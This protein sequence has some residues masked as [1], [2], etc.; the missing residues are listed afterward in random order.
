MR[1]WAQAARI[2]E[3]VRKQMGRWQPS[4]DEEYERSV[5]ANV[6]RAQSLVAGFVKENKGRS[7]PFDEATVLAKVVSRMG[8]MGYDEVD[9]D[10]QVDMLLSFGFITESAEPCRTPVWS[11]GLGV[12]SFEG[13]AL[14]SLQGDMEA[15]AVETA[16]AQD[17]DEDEVGETVPEVVMAANE[18][19]RYVVCISGRTQRRT[20]HK[21]GECH[22]IPGLHYH[23]FEMLS[24]EPPKAEAYHHAC[25]HC[26]PQRAAEPHDSAEDLSSGEA[27][28][29]EDTEG[30]SGESDEVH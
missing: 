22:R 21:M 1:T 19:G 30:H 23:N 2:P 9:K 13:R 25:Q 24:Y 11:A 15:V 17:M 12:V 4:A 20:L 27:S 8:D 28:S 18:R 29:S 14:P 7:D 3:N 5:G 6:C 16:E 26:F 10:R